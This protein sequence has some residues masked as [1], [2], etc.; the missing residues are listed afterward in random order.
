[1]NTGSICITHPLKCRQRKIPSSLIRY[2]RSAA[3]IDQ[4]N[5]KFQFKKA[6]I[7]TKLSRYEFEQHKN[8][9]LTMIQLEKVL[10]DRGTDYDLL[11]SYHRVHKE[12]EK[13]VADSFKEYGIDVKLVNR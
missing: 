6:L 11:L 9:K 8:P 10:R 13:K 5:R 1:M 2:Y 7:V 4:S 12:F 3:S